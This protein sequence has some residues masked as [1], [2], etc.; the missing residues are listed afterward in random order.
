MMMIK[1]TSMTLNM[2]MCDSKQDDDDVDGCTS[3]I[4]DD[5]AY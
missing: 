3:V 4:I 2:M 1:T 5:D